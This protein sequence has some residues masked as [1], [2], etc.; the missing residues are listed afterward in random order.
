MKSVAADLAILPSS[1]PDGSSVHTDATHK[2]S[3]E[4]LTPAAGMLRFPALD[5]WRGISILLV[6]A[7]HLFPLG[8]KRFDVNESVA[9]LGMA[10][11]FTLSGFLIT[12]TLLNRPSVVEFLIRRFCRILP[13]AWVFTVFGLAIARTPLPYFRAQL[14]F[15][16]NLPP[17]YL[18]NQTA[19]LWSLCVEMQFYLTIA[20][21]CAIF[22]RRG[23][24]SIPVL[25]LFVTAHRI[26]THTLLSIVTFARVDEILAGGT[27]ALICSETLYLGWARRFLTWVSPL[28]LLPLALAASNHFTG[29]LNY[30]RPYLAAAM[31]GSTLLYEGTPGVSRHLHAKWL[32]YIAAISYAL[33]IFHPMVEWGWL[34]AGSKVVRYAKRLPELAAVFG[35]A[36][37][38]T[39]YFEDFWIRKGKQWSKRFA[40]RFPVKPPGMQDEPARRDADRRQ[41]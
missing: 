25:C 26:Q 23:L 38:S 3:F 15:Y 2:P 32:A 9:A 18:T 37:L 29:P 13:L 5:G 28:A 11:F 16:S 14:L 7:G 1:V 24:W 21:I 35:L 12:T 22:G 6:M 40:S 4:S 10:I 30:F 8:P 31:V 27:L 36:H 20:V 41:G 39:F 34:A 17:F 33:Y 19:H